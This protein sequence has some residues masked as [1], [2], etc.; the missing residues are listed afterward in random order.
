MVRLT[1]GPMK[2][3]LHLLLHLLTAVAQRLGRGGAKSLV[4]ENLL[5][6]R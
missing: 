4:V 3:L 1:L 6:K 5:V 2:E